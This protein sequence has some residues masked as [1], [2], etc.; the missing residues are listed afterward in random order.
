[1]QLATVLVS[2]TNAVFSASVVGSVL[3]SA[4]NQPGLVNCSLQGASTQ[5]AA[6][7]WT[8][9]PPANYNQ[10]FV[11]FTF[12]FSGAFTLPN[13]TPVDLVCN[14]YGVSGPSGGVNGYLTITPVGSFA[15]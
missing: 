14:F 11:Y 13:P 3:T 12:E 1:M 15:S 5:L 9:G 7:N 2:E 4:V 8:L 6:G 10:P